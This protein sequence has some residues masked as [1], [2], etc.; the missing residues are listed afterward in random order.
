ML[1]TPFYDPNKSYEDNYDQGPF[2]EFSN[3]KDLRAGEEPKY[4]FLGFK[5]N[6]P[7]GVL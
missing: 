1:K 3:G 7:F 2:G 4:E 6:T 5:I